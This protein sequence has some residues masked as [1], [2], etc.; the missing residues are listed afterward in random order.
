MDKNPIPKQSTKDQGRLSN[1]IRVLLDSGS[2]VD[3]YFLPNGKDKPFPYLTRQAPKS[4]HMSN[5]SFQT[6]VRGKFRLKYLSILL[7]GSTPYNLRLCN[8]MNII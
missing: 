4:W 7:T 1:K 3:L 5:G 8:M 2:D 6:N